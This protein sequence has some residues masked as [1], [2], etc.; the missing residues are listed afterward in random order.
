MG[1]RTRNFYS[2]RS[3]VTGVTASPASMMV[4]RFRLAVVAAGS[5]VDALNSTLPP[6]ATTLVRTSSSQ[7]PSLESCA[8]GRDSE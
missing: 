5:E 2:S 4:S 8:G 6:R 1:N 7:Q 3:A